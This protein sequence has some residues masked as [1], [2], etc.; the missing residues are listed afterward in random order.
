MK[1]FQRMMAMTLALMLFAS[2]SCLSVLGAETEPGSSETASVTQEETTEAATTPEISEPAETTEATELPVE[3]TGTASL[4]EEPEAT[5][6]EEPVEEPGTTVDMP[7]YVQ[8]DYPETAFGSGTVADCGSSVTA[9]AMVSSYL[10]GYDYTPDVLA[11]YFYSVSDDASGLIGYGAKTLG[12]HCRE[13][14]DFRD[15][16]QALEEGRVVICQMNGQSVFTSDTHIIVLKEITA[17]G[18]IYVS[19]PL[20][21][22]REKSML[23]EGFEKGFPKGWI[24]TG[25]ETAWIFDP[26]EGEIPLYT[27][28]A[29]KRG[30][31][32]L[33]NQNDYKDVMYGDGTIASDGC[34][35]TALAMVATSMTGH[36]YTPD[37]LA[38]YFGG[39]NGNN[40][41]RLLNASDELQLPW[42]AAANWHKAL[43]ELKQ[44]KLAIILVNSR[45]MFADCQHFIVATG[46]TE[47]G[48]VLINDPNG[49]NYSNPVLKDGFA[50]GFTSSQIATGYSGAWIYD[51]D[52]MPEKPFIYVEEEVYV[53]PR[54]T[55]LNLSQEDL[56]LLAKL[57]W[58][59]ARG[60]EADGQQAV[61]EVI[62]NRLASGQF[63][64]TMC[65]VVYA[66]NQFIGSNYIDQAEPNQTQYDAV[67]RALNGPY[68]LPMEVCHF[69]TY[70][71]NKDVWGTIGRHT[72]CYQW[73]P[74]E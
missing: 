71:V 57:V 41:E 1:V 20:R 52:A 22:N 68:I 56:R 37:Q 16:L 64:S 5:P 8:E 21:S 32:P 17:E 34:G 44:G 29:Y 24:S 11:D 25:W 49:T 59:E 72:F 13:A 50:N 6:T 7:D 47:D 65:S 30:Q 9:L 19:D 61:A 26:V 46:V 14:E 18:R 60:E 67:E 69:A 53:E 42:H 51:V 2:S 28:E 31:M 39:Y 54:Y 45:S 48:K 35:I 23:R 63:Q 62:L 58:V 43:E 15:I 12:L 73:S 55:E 3:E 74:D 4:P 70:P 38:D 66:E 33:Y 27:G 10:T 36:T 40:I